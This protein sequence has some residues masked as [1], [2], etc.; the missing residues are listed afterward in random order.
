[1]WSHVVPVPLV[2]WNCEKPLKETATRARG[3]CRVGTT[4]WISADHANLSPDRTWMN[5]SSDQFRTFSGPIC[6]TQKT[7]P[8]RTCF[9]TQIH[10]C[11]F[12]VFGSDREEISV[13]TPCQRGDR[14]AVRL[15]G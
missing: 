12:A 4:P 7:Q 1:M 6:A 10:D 2:D 11:G 15:A 5:K 3:S 13:G 8:K 14:C 9:L